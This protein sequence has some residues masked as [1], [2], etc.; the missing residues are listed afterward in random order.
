MAY[1]FSSNDVSRYVWI[2]IITKLVRRM[3]MSVLF[4]LNDNTI[5]GVLF[6]KKFEWDESQSIENIINNEGESIS[7][8]L[9]VDKCLEQ[10][11]EIET[12]QHTYKIL[13]EFAQNNGISE[14]NLVKDKKY[15]T[16]KISELMSVIG[17]VPEFQQS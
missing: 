7:A 14:I 1:V 6:N 10:L 16:K 2:G 11:G 9:C 5:V 13:V 8:K 3:V 12:S 15:A 4:K 17:S